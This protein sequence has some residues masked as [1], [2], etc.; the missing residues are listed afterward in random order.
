MMNSNTRNE[1]W[2]TY[3]PF[4][5][6]AIVIGAIALMVGGVV[7]AFLLGGGLGTRSQYA[8]EAIIGAIII[9]LIII[10]QQDE[11][12][13]VTVI[14]VNLYFDW[15][16]GL[17]IVALAIAL[18]L[19]VTFFLARSCQRPWAKPRALWL[20]VLFLTLMIPPAIRGA[21]TLR[22]TLIYYPDLVLGALITFWLGTVIAR[23]IQS[24]RRLFQILAVFG[25]L[26]AVH[27]IIQTITG[28]TLLG[29]SQADAYLATVS[30]YEL[31]DVARLGSF[32]TQ[33]N[34]C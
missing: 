29:T 21:L 5:Y 8:V 13:A 2:E 6:F 23:D 17:Y 26:I 33:P 25:V 18:T 19:L 16:L 20:W 30:N 4:S 31:T 27:M 9:A 32:F 22:D 34:F 24:V 1:K 10:L 7:I 15:Y 12:A 28:V 14:A 3:L 11:L